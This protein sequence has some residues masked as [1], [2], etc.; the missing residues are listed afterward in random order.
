MSL[1]FADS[2]R[3]YKNLRKAPTQEAYLAL[4][5]KLFDEHELLPE[6]K[7]LPNA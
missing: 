4:L 5:N 1:C 3:V 2:F 6:P 7:F